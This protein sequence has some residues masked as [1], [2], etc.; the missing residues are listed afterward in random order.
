MQ[1]VLKGIVFH[2]FYAILRDAEA[3]VLQNVRHDFLLHGIGVLLGIHRV[4]HLDLQ[5]CQF[6]TCAFRFQQFLYQCSLLRI[7]LQ[8]VVVDT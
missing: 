2:L 5:L 3:I 1:H 7:N 8:H 4:N 6:G